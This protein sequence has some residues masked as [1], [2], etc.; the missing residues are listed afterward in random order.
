MS[1]ITIPL[2]ENK[3]K[4]NRIIESLIPQKIKQDIIILK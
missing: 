3:P 2:S 4:I 1:L